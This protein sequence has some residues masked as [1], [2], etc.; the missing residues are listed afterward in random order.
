MEKHRNVNT[1]AEQLMTG[2]LSESQFAAIEDDADL[3]D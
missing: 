2:A 3:Y 1:V